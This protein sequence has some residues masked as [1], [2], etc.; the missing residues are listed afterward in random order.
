MIIVDVFWKRNFFAL[1][2]NANQG[3]ILD[4]LW[5]IN[6]YKKNTK[7]SKEIFQEKKY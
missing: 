2:Q 6:I 1:T 4:H 7:K 5:I 3:L